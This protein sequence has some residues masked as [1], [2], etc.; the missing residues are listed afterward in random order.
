MPWASPFIR[1]S[2]SDECPTRC[3]EGRDSVASAHPNPAAP[4]HGVAPGKGPDHAESLLHPRARRGDGGAHGGGRAVAGPAADHLD[5]PNLG[6]IHVDPS[7]NLPVTKTKVH[8]ISTMSTCSRA[9]S[10]N[11]TV[12]AM[13][14]QSGCQPRDRPEHVRGRRGLHVQHRHQQELADRPAVRSSFGKPNAHGVQSYKVTFVKGDHRHVVARGWT[15]KS[16]WKHASARL[17]ASARTRSSS[18]CLASWAPSRARAPGGSMTA[19]RPTS[20]SA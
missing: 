4:R 18:I 20:S 9:P 12:L 3:R 2:T 7:D 11:H 13:T 1:Q 15:G 10:A 17:P 19:S 14:G 6:S 5:A 8:S 16:T